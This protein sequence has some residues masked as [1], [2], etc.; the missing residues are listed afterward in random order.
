MEQA[1]PQHSFSL[2]WDFSAHIFIIFSFDCTESIW[3]MWTISGIR[4]IRAADF[5]N[6]FVM[7]YFVP[8]SSVEGIFSLQTDMKYNSCVLQI[9]VNQNTQS[10]YQVFFNQEAI[11]LTIVI[12]ILDQELFQWLNKD[13][14]EYLTSIIPIFEMTL[15]VIFDCSNASIEW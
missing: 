13:H 5:E 2:Q 15:R 6:R 9:K 8:K 14:L 4:L 10:V 12:R 1:K 3:S 11:S 7:F